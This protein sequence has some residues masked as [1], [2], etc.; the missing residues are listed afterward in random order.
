MPRAALGCTLWVRRQ[1]ALVYQH[2]R[3][4]TANKPLCKAELA[5]L[6][7]LSCLEIKEGE[8]AAVEGG[9]EAAGGAEVAAVEAGGAEVAAVEAGGAEVAAVEAGAE[10][11]GG[12]EAGGQAAAPLRIDAGARNHMRAATTGCTSSVHTIH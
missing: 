9:A 8:V 1:Q 10:A 11:V 4:S 6:P 12:E 3:Q 7:P 2:M 5:N